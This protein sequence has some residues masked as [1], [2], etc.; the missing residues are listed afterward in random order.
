MS[1]EL[2]F[3]ELQQEARLFRDQFQTAILSTSAKDGVSVASYAPFVLDDS[4]TPYIFISQ[5]AQHTQNLLARSSLS[6]LFIAD[7][8]ASKN[9][10]ARQRLTLNC[11][12]I[13][14]SRESNTGIEIL[15]LFNEKFGKMTALLQSLNDFHLF[16]LNVETGSYVRGFGQA[17]SI[18]N[19]RLTIKQQKRA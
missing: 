19:A 10:F 6:I 5:L 9:L 7:E 4:E 16:Q 15:A 11:N 12:A 2:D 3:T 13:E 18:A 17:Y 1:E 8:Q 14:V